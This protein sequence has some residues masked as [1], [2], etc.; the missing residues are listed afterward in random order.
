MSTFDFTLPDV[1][2]G[3]AEAEIIEWSV[4]VGDSVTI[5]Q[6]VAVIETDKSQIE[7]PVPV[8]GKR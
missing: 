5:D 1:G 8:A 2:E 7:M 4:V 6:V 3:I